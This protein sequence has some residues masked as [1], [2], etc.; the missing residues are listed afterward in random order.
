M[1]EIILAGYNVDSTTLEQATQGA[2]D[3]DLLTPEPLTAA[4]ARISRLRKPVGELREIAREEVAKARRSNQRIVFEMGHAA[5][6]EHAVF[7]FDIIGAS[8]LAIEFIEKFRLGCGYTEK[9]QRY[10][11]LDGDYVMPQELKPWEGEFRELVEKQNRMYQRIFKAVR[12]QKLRELNHEPTRNERR[13]IEGIAKEDARYVTCLATEGQLGATYNA[14]TLENLIRQSLFHPLQEVKEI[15]RT[16]YKE[17]DRVAPSLVIYAD[18]DEYLKTRGRNLDLDILAHGE[19]DLVTATEALLGEVSAPNPREKLEEVTRIDARSTTELVLASLI[20][21]GSK[22]RLG[23]VEAMDVV[24][25]SQVPQQVRFLQGTLRHQSSH[26][27]MPREYELQQSSFTWEVILSAACFGQVKRHRI[28]SLTTVPYDPNLG[29]T[30]P[31][32]VKQVGLKS[33]MQDICD[34]SAELFY[35]IAEQEPD[36]AVYALTNAHRRRAII[37]AN[38]RELHH[39]AGLRMD[40]HAQWDIRAIATEM[41]RQAKEIEPL[42]FALATGKH[43][44]PERHRDFLGETA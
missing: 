18:P 33:E 6:A 3:P 16:L 38:P 27:S 36:A 15:G 5:V 37:S 17:A 31:E 28:M 9:S 2:I 12:D 30:V 20:T 23:L 4:Y 44:F 26:H 24:Q 43:E 19:K 7:N 32:T 21:R 35:T 11:E 8:R 22:G 25:R 34:A 39:I 41:I 1:A 29:I 42:I 14:R 13:L 40:A 10:I